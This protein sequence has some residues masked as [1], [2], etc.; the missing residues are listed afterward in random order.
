MYRKW[1]RST[2]IDYTNFE[3][4]TED[5]ERIDVTGLGTAPIDVVS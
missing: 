1:Y 5:I 2:Q 4:D 3:R